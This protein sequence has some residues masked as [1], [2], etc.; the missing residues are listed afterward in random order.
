MDQKFEIFYGPV[1]YTEIEEMFE[2]EFEE[3]RLIL[4]A[5]VRVFK[6]LSNAAQA[7]K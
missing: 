2:E 4:Q 1:C 6:V 5:R 3:S 7:L